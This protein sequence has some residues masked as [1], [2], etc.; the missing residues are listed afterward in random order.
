[1]SPATLR[2]KFKD[3]DVE[4]RRAAVLAAAM[5]EDK[6]V[7]PDILG[8]LSD[9]SPSVWRAVPVALRLLSGKELN[10]PSNATAAEREKARIQWEEWW[11][12]SSI[13]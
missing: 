8:L 6:S 5:N 3:T 11:R 7:I 1:M 4:I 2:D 9:P 13:K 12:K 10:L